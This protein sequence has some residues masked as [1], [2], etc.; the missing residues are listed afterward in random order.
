MKGQGTCDLVQALSGDVVILVDPLA[1]AFEV[2][3]GGRRRFTG[4]FD[5]SVLYDECVLWLTLEFRQRLSWRRGEG[6]RQNFT[7]V[8]AVYTQTG[9]TKQQLR[10]C[11]KNPEI[12]RQLPDG[13]Y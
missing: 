6:V 2:D 7:V 13:H 9:R 4:K 5:W 12:M 11:A 3:L 1:V 10:F 8:T